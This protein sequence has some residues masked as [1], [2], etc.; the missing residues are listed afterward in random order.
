MSAP[1]P[2]AVAAGADGLSRR[3]SESEHQRLL[4]ARLCAPAPGASPAADAWAGSP[5]SGAAMEHHQAASLGAPQGPAAAAQGPE[6]TVPQRPAQQAAAY[7][8][9]AGSVSRRR[10]RAQPR[11]AASGFAQLEAERRKRKLQGIAEEMLEKERDECTFHPR[12]NQGYLPKE[13]RPKDWCR[14][15]NC[16]RKAVWLKRQQ[17]KALE[18]EE[19]ENEFPF[20]PQLSQTTVWFASQRGGGA[21]TPASP[22]CVYRSARKLYQDAEERERRQQ[23]HRLQL[24]A[25]EVEGLFRPRVNSL[26]P[27]TSSC[28]GGGD[29]PLYERLEEV[30]SA[31]AERKHGLAERW[32]QEQ[33]LTFR[34]TIHP[35]SH[36]VAAQ[37]GPLVERLQQQ[38]TVCPGT[39]KEAAARQ[40]TADGP[41]L[42]SRTRELA[43]QREAY[44]RHQDF[45]E[46]QIWE[47][48]RRESRL[49]HLRQE[50][51]ATFKVRT[52]RKPEEQI[53]AALQEMQ[54]R[55]KERNDR[56]K[57]LN[58]EM[59]QGLF[60]PN[61]QVQPCTYLGERRPARRAED[62]MQ[63][64]R[65]LTEQW[66]QD[67]PFAPTIDRRSERLAAKRGE[68]SRRLGATLY[69]K[70][71]DAA[72]NAERMRDAAQLREFQECTFRPQLAPGRGEAAADP[73]P[74]VAGMSQFVRRQQTAQEME[75]E[76]REREENAHRVRGAHGAVREDLAG[77][78]YTVPEP[79]AFEGGARKRSASV[80]VH[81]F[82]PRTNETERRRVL[83]K[84]LAEDEECS[85]AFAHD[86]ESAPA[87]PPALSGLPGWPAAARGTG[88][89]RRA[90]PGSEAA[91]DAGA[92]DSVSVQHIDL[93]FS[94]H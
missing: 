65:A 11:V 13:E 76:R 81:T 17:Q 6:G 33:K 80:P 59:H 39:A 94:Y 60:Q 90:P 27:D 83:R 66:K 30:L 68:G 53:Q 54:R 85:G 43:A 84:V 69:A 50:N 40:C 22:P 55:T 72:R 41:C 32:K 14:R 36:A 38:P 1:A 9:D 12:I 73:P 57:R 91:R 23:Q 46:R 42:G 2:P 48:E 67:C 35:L 3:L 45:V 89:G 37:R 63:I 61:T 52:Q 70:R 26:A 88:G 62:E 86:D 34:P 71:P 19:K 58:D 44:R 25:R 47:Q 75:R 79:F 4:E 28:D 56:V 49:N 64:E 20:R 74:R 16:D 93:D 7:D 87:P 82:Q 5:T 18:E 51:D 31:R 92:A 29:R 77:R 21:E 24:K 8:S 78:R 15:L 10:A